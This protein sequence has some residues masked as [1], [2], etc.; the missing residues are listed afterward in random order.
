MMRRVFVLIGLALAGV[1]CLFASLFVYFAVVDAVKTA[2]G[3]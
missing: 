1:V 3:V 2:L